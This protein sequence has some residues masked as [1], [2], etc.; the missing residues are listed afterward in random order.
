MAE[1]SAARMQETLEKD[2]AAARKEA[3]ASAQP[4]L[5]EMEGSPNMTHAS[6]S[7][8]SITPADQRLVVCIRPRTLVSMTDT[9]QFSGMHC[10]VIADEALTALEGKDREL[11][12]KAATIERLS[13]ELVSQTECVSKLFAEVCPEVASTADM[14]QGR[15]TTL[16]LP[17]KQNLRHLAAPLLPGDPLGF[18]S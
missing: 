12:A 7:D 9:A 3:E 2:V 1:G 8:S 6:P 18:D 4:R 14:L 13:A 10:A 15:H 17:V 5:R 16:E 11:E